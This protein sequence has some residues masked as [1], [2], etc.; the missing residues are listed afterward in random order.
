MSHDVCSLSLA[1]VARGI[2]LGELDPVG[3]I[4]AHL[5]RISA[6]NP[7]LNAFTHVCER[8]AL[9]RARRLARASRQHRG[10]LPLSGVPIAI[11]DLFDMKAGLPNT[12]GSRLFAHNVAAR[13]ALLVRR[14]E[15]AGAIVVGKTNTSEFGHRATTDNLLFGPTSTPIRTGYN[16]GG[17]SG[18]SAA[19]VAAS[20]VTVATGSDGAGSIRV[21]ASLCGVVGVKPTWGRVPTRPR[22]NG[23][24]STV[25]MSSAGVLARSVADAT[26]VL[27][28]LAAP[29]TL[30]PNSFPVPW[31]HPVADEPRSY[32]IAFTRD[33][34]IFPVAL[35]VIKAAEAAVARLRACGLVVED[36]DAQ[37]HA[38]YDE[39]V[40]VLLDYVALSMWETLRDLDVDVHAEAGRGMLAG[41]LADLAERGARLSAGRLRGNDVVRTKVFDGL[42]DMLDHFDCVLTPTLA[43]AGVPNAAD[44]GA[45]VGPSSVAGRRTEPLLGWSLAFPVNLTGHPAVSLPA[46]RTGEDLVVGMQLIGRRFCDARLLEVAASVEQQLAANSPTYVSAEVHSA[47]K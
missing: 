44:P 10:E 3:V 26:A 39:L 15:A 29:D 34:G 32:R 36:A 8:D 27:K 31:D 33:L 17:S 24:R 40:E 13:D 43:V 6:V 4:E 46:G 5:E 14:L 16:A 9:E 19:A 7:A 38:D 37:L 12:F 28:V 30:D 45:T 41:T 20:M 23:F 1:A 47:R 11:K 18:G 42:E 25:P 2:R 21:P 22:P 35:D